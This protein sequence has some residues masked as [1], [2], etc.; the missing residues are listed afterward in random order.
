MKILRLELENFRG[1]KNLA[2]DFDG[3]DTDIFGANGTGKTTVANAICW[4]LIDRPATEE[5]D[6]DPKTT[7]A[8]GI[9]HVATIEI[10]TESGNQISLSKD[11]Y[12]KWTRKRGAAESEFTGNTTDYFIDGVRAKKKQ[13]TAAV[14]RACGTSLDNLK[15]LMVLGYFADTMSTDDKRKI[16]FEMAGDFTDADIFAQNES[17][18]ALAPYLV[19]PGSSGKSYAIEQWQK[20]AKEQRQKLNKDL[21]LLPTRIDEAAKGIPEEVGDIAALQAE[22]QRLDAEKAAAEEER[23]SL[24]TADGKKDAIRT[25]VANLRV[26]MENARAAYIKE[27]VEKN[28]DIHAAIDK[29]SGEKRTLAEEIDTIKRKVRDAEAQKERM[30]SLRTSLM[31]EYAAAQAEQWDAGK[32]TCPTCGQALPAEKVQELRAAFNERKAQQKESINRRGQECSKAKIQEMEETI[33]AQTANLTEKEASLA[34][35]AERLQN[36]QGSLIVQPPFEATDGYTLL[37]QRMEELHDAE[38][39]GDSAQDETARHYDAKVQEIQ[40]AIA[41]TNLRIAEAKTV[42][43]SKKR[44]AELEASLKDTAAQLEYIEHGIHL[45]EEFV[46]TKARMVTDSINGHFNL[47]RFVLFREQING[48][49]KEICEPTL[50]NKAGEWVEY[51][52]ANYAAQVNA[53]VDIIGALSRHYG[54]TLPILMDQAESVTAPLET[55]GQLIRLIVS[56]PDTGALRVK[57]KE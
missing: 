2:I 33:A 42:A 28:R 3:K 41:A 21:E 17:L 38:R 14:E 48:G 26:E 39:I 44:V 52:S 51:R 9:H 24:S 46:R 31:E 27:G 45:A 18:Q 7:G 25:A 22:L 53:K 10:E 15:M 4:L 8:H 32:E 23:R 13:Y 40:A 16:L 43:E 37:A 1:I 35:M 34:D 19:M 55:D 11:F 30:A 20:I 5:P 12:E 54:V 6:F 57:V 49:L 56:A 36:L 50:E 47:V 29:L